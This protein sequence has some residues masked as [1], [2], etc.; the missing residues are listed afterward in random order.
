[1]LAKFLRRLVRRVSGWFGA[2]LTQT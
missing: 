2:G 1:V